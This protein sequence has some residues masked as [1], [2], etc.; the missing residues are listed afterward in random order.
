M[1]TYIVTILA[2]ICTCLVIYVLTKIAN[3]LEVIAN[4]LSAHSDLE[5]INIAKTHNLSV[6]KIKN[7]EKE[8]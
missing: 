8:R 7:K 4:N 1:M 6:N 5:A 2:F 3:N